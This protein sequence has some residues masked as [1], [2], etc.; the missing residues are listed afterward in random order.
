MS[1]GFVCVDMHIILFN[2]T[3]E[4]LEKVEFKIAESLTKLNMSRPIA[5]LT[6]FDHASRFFRCMRNWFHIV[7]WISMDPLQELGWIWKNVANL[8]F[9]NLDVHFARY[10]GNPWN[11]EH[12]WDPVLFSESK[13]VR[14]FGVY[15]GSG[16]KQLFK[17]LYVMLAKGSGY[18]CWNHQHLHMGVSVNGGTPR[19]SILIGFSITNHPFWGTTIFGNIHIMVIYF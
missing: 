5:S 1:L 11:V 7:L 16:F 3:L 12:H 18:V 14:F 4:G 17:F 2:L 9:N 8:R 13:H 10:P 6:C 15:L 19:S